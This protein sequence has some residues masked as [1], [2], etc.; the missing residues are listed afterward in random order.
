MWEPLWAVMSGG[1]WGFLTTFVGGAV[2]FGIVQPL[3]R[4]CDMESVDPLPDE[5]A[6]QLVARLNRAAVQ[7]WETKWEE[8]AGQTWAQHLRDE[9]TRE[10]KREL[11]RRHERAMEHQAKISA[12]EYGR[13]T[14]ILAKQKREA[15]DAPLARKFSQGGPV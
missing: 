5:S 11:T 12:W 10:W 13:Q 9:E 6:D 3:R 1:G 8:L 15:Q 7:D 2:W 4:Q 14:R